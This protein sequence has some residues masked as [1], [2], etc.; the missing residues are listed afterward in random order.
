MDSNMIVMFYVIANN[1]RASILPFCYVL[2]QF[3]V[4]VTEHTIIEAWF[5]LSTKCNKCVPKTIIL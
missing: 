2:F 3:A 1:Y 5:L 4:L